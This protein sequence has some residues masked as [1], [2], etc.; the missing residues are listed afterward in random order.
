[1]HANSTQ[2]TE[3]SGRRLARARPP[4]ETA[5]AVV[6]LSGE[7]GAGKTTFARGFL[8]A[9]GVANPVRSPTYTLIEP[10][11][12]GALVIVHVD[13]YRLRDPGELDG[14]GLSDYARPGHVWLIEWPEH[15]AGRLPP[16][17]LTV[18][19]RA[20]ERGHDIQMQAHSSSG[21][22]W[23]AALAGGTQP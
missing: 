18:S 7:L 21:E 12:C 3:E 10:Y 23:L 2:D 1:M 19:L 20:S 13:L 6:Y 9:C 22:S 16:P 15:G 5:L 17:D 4:G 8:G 14:L 11:T